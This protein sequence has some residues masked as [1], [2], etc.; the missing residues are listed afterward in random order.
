M[1]THVHTHMHTLTSTPICMHTRVYMCVCTFVC[2][3]V[4]MYVC[5][6]GICFSV[7][8]GAST[9]LKFHQNWYP[10]NAFVTKGLEW[11]SV[12]KKNYLYNR[13]RNYHC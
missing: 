11:Y 1:H 9:H 3:H 2:V 12:I 4:C 6:V 13:S 10:T 7:L 5:M 8:L